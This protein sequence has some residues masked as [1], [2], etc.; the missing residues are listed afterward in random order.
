MV[1]DAEHIG[2][3]DRDHDAEQQ[4]YGR[5]GKFYKPA[6]LADSILRAHPIPKE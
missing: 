2:Y 6:P 3:R 4:Q 5:A 1:Y